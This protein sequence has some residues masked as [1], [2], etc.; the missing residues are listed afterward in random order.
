MFAA[1]PPPPFEA[2]QLGHM[3]I[4]LHGLWADATT[5]RM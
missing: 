5:A 1:I 3:R 2:I 4:T